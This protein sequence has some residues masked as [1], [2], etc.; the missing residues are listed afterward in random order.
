MN[1]MMRSIKS[2]KGVTLIELLVIVVILGI[3]A[4]VVIPLVSGNTEDAY[5]NTNQQ[6]LKI[7]Q[8]AK[9]RYSIG[10]N[11][12]PATLAAIVSGGYITEIPVVYD[13][14][15]NA[16]TTGDETSGFAITDDGGTPALIVS[17]ALHGDAAQ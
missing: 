16:V 12:N 13:S 5:I 3:I 14:D 7:L 6:N 4:A 9:E 17:I 8:D 11:G 1:A 2:K 10:E 15:G